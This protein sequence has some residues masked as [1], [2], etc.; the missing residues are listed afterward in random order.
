MVAL[1]TT[2]SREAIPKDLEALLLG[3]E[4]EVTSSRTADSVKELPQ[5]MQALL[6]M[7]AQMAYSKDRHNHNSQHNAR[8]THEEKA[9][10]KIEDYLK[11][12]PNCVKLVA[13]FAMKVLSTKYRES[14]SDW[15]GK[16]GII[17]HGIWIVWW[18]PKIQKLRYYFIN[19]IVTDSTEDGELVVQRIALAL[20]NHNQFFPH[21]DECI[22]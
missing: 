7:K 8:L 22:L 17:W 14:M 5:E 19:Q 9:D 12:N 18:D 13:D 21:A 3:M 4:V 15:F 10:N 6:S 11:N 2:T 1:R 20:K 16:K